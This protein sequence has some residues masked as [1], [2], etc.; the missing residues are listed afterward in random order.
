MLFGLA[1]PLGQALIV[2][3][4]ALVEDGRIERDHDFRRPHAGFWVNP[5]RR[6]HFR[7]RRHY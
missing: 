4:Y 3:G 6:D 7:S 2:G 5:V 1:S